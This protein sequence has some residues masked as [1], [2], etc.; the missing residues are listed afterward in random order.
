MHKPITA[1]IRAEEQS[2][3]ISS[4]CFDFRLEFTDYTP[5]A[6]NC[7]TGALWLALPIAMR[8]GRPLHIAGSLDQ[9]SLDNAAKLVTIWTSWLPEFFRP[10]VVTC[11][12]ILTIHP[13]E[14][15]S[16]MLML[17]SGGVDSSYAL[18]KDFIQQGIKVDALTIHGMDYRYDDAPRFQALMEKTRPLRAQAIERHYLIKSNV[19]MQMGRNGIGAGYGHGFHLFGCLFMFSGRYQQGAIAADFPL[20][21]E[22]IL[23][24]W[25][26]TTLTNSLFASSSFSVKTLC[27]DVARPEKTGLLSQNP[28]ALES[29]SFCVNYKFRPENC[30]RCS[31][32]VRTKANF[33]AETGVIPPIFSDNSFHPE[34]LNE[35]DMHVKV[36]R[37]AAI[38]LINTAE[39]TGQ[40]ELLA[41][42][43]QLMNNYIHNQ[44]TLA[45]KNK[46]KKRWLKKITN[47]K[48][49]W[50]SD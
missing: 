49:L 25:G 3:H 34:D 38:N 32:C 26:T 24:P 30:G 7:Y 22:Y 45:I 28:A 11:N 15:R 2:L 44:E 18:C 48:K 17:F 13:G 27:N 50:K 36:D 47:L 5:A 10:I 40:T 35:M 12:E 42:L 8:L 16:P 31:K 33:L 29:L 21:I 46:R 9:V 43:R 39:R 14:N 1:T 41:K 23:A 4:D 37:I 20:F 6:E 19:V